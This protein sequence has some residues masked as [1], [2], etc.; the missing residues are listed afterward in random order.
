MTVRRALGTLT[1]I[2]YFIAADAD[3]SGHHNIILAPYSD[4]PTPQR[5]TRHEA[6]TL[7]EIDRLQRQLQD[8]EL[9]KL[10]AEN[11]A[12]ERASALG[13]LRV[14]ESMRARMISSDTSPMERDFIEAY[15]ALREEKREANHRRWEAAQVYL[16]ARENDLGDRAPDSE[17]V[18]LD[19]LE[20]K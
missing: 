15:L 8:Q 20:V 13:R 7:P 18:N 17:R 16:H 9:R 3:A 2:I 4:Y 19:H 1:P 12:I 10:R 11:L 14:Y 5:H 6:G